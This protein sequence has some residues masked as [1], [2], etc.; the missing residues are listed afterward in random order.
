MTS[1]FHT[2]FHTFSDG[3]LVLN[4]GPVE[5]EIKTSDLH[6]YV[7]SIAAIEKL[8]AQED[9]HRILSAPT[10][11]LTG[12]H[13]KRIAYVKD[14]DTYALTYH[15]ASWEADASVAVAAAGEVMASFANA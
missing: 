15:R 1:Q 4:I 10:S 2:A 12:S 8:R 9:H 13:W 6:V 7:D 14:R 11:L 5:L 3:R